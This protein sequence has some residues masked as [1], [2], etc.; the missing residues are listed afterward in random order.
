[1]GSIESTPG[2]D[3]WEFFFN[4]QRRA[5]PELQLALFFALAARKMWR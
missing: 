2:V 5:R 1:M 3:F 4:R